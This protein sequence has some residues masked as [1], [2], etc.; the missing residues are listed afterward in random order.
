MIHSFDTFSVR[1][2]LIFMRKAQSEST[3]YQPPMRKQYDHLRQAS[4]CPHCS[5]EKRCCDAW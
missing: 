2:E 3:L 4:A 5:G 1:E